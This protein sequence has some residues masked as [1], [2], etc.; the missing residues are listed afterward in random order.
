MKSKQSPSYRES[1]DLGD[2]LFRK[3]LF[4][5]LQSFGYQN[6]NASFSIFFANAKIFE[7]EI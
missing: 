4:S 5:Y 6:L 7:V 2:C 1:E 3:N